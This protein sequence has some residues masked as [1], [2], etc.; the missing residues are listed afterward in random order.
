MTI[1]R[2]QLLRYAGATFFTAIG[3]TFLSGKKTYGAQTA[4]TTAVK[5]QWLGH[6]CFL[7]SGN[8][9]RV[10]INPFETLGC[11]AG[12]RLPP[13]QA[14]LVLISS[15]LLD[16][17]AVEKV[18][19]NPKI[20]AEPGD[21]QIKGLKFQGITIAHDREGGRRFGDNIAWRWTQGGINFLHLGGAAAPIEIEQKILMGSPDIVLI[22][23]GGG[24]K[25]YNPEEAKQA[26]EV[27]KPKLVI[28]TQYLTKAA[29]KSNCDLLP[30]E[31]FLETVKGMPTNRYGSS[32]ISIKRADLPKEGTVVRV[33]SEPQT[34]ANK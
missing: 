26:I 10:L 2:R 33:F 16:E 9:L 18:P 1:E 29:D 32:T 17:G 30:V 12:Y 28:P 31:N 3:T 15:Y 4:S 22:P 34:V 23:V 11:T 5:V 27:L 25:S 8:G 24:A 7:F 20:L 6:S 13:I 14:D 19:G 21:Y